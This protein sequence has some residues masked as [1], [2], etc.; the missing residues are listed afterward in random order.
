[1]AVDTGLVDWVTEAMAPIGTVTMRRMMSGATL[2]LDGTVFA[3]VG[4]DALWFKADAESDAA[5]D[6]AGCARFT[7]E[8]NG[9]PKSMNYRRAPDDVYDDADVLR[10]WGE[11][12]VAAGLRAPPKKPRSKKGVTRPG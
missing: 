2:Y 12:A 6:A 4:R 9:Q 3:I 5:W 10:E 1:M 8:M 11:L 7:V